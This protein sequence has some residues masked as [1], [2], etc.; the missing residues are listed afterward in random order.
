MKPM[1]ILVV[2]TSYPYGQNESFVK[3]ELDYLAESFD[4]VELVPSYYSPDSAPR[5]TALPVNLGYANVRWG[6]RRHMVLLSSI[7][8]GLWCYPWQ[9][10]A[11][12]VMRGAHRWKNF[13]ELARA[14]YRARL[15]ERFLVEQILADKEIDVVYFYWMFPEILGAVR[16]R[17]ACQPSLKVV[18][19][20]HGGDLYEDRRSGGYAGL[21]QGVLDGI[22][23]VYNISDHGRVYLARAYPAVAKKCFTARLGVDAPGF[24]NAQPQEAALSILSCSF[25]VEEKRLHLLVD[26]IAHLLDEDPA[27]A[28]RWTHIGDGALFC[29]LRAYA[30]SRLEGRADLVFTGYLAPQD[31][32]ALYR[33][34]PFDVIVNV[35]SREGIPVSLMEASSVGIPMIATD[36]GGNREIVNEHNGVLIP[37]TADVATIARALSR[38][39]DR[40]SSLAYRAR[41]RA[42][43]QDKFNAAN[44][45]ARFGKA[46]ANLASGH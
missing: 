38:F 46:L 8:A 12:R 14:L 25:V 23:A 11:L 24:V 40:A 22:D 5:P 35:S 1:R 37:A 21:R 34:Q 18:A 26:A 45:Y 20:A 28:I 7:V 4:E 29:D 16:F 15:F 19:R 2:T 39:R 42:D 10:D 36:V 32:M 3:A 30:R 27:L 6:V 44:N 9:G 33:E 43:W 41:A 17:D 31:V 13:K